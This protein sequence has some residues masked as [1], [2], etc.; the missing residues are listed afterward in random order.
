MEGKEFTGAGQNKK[1]ARN[2]AAEIAL[3]ALKWVGPPAG[4]NVT[5]LTLRQK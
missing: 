4:R 1:Q 3:T 2:I 5:F